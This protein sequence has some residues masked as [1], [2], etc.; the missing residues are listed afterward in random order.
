MR[1]TMTKEVT[2]TTIK[3][4]EMVVVDGLPMAQP[5]D[6]HIVL[7]NVNMEKAQ[8]IVNK[9]FGTSVTVFGVEPET[10]VYEMK[11]EDFIKIAKVK[12]EE[13]VETE[14]DITE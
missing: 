6:D 2:H 4:A 8:K 12:D 1:A 7:G 5:L 9:E 3:I 14:T 13:E 10:K 11:V